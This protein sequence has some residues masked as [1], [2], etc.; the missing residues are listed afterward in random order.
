MGVVRPHLWFHDRAEEAA[1][2]YATVIPNSSVTRV[3]SAPDGIPGVEAGAPFIVEF[4]LDGMPVTALNAGPALTLDDAFSMYLT[5]DDQQ[6]VDHYW[7]VL[8]ADGGSPGR[9]GWLRDRFGLSWQVVPRA[10]D[11]IMTRADPAAVARATTVM[12]GMG[13]LDVAA[14]EAAFAG[15]QQVAPRT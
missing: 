4:V 13:K 7:E 2:F 8:T 12:L 6:E 11:E 3:V 1:A 14:L 15:D 5:C 9:C 10:L